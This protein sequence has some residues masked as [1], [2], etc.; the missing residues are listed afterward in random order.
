VQH[1]IFLTA[2]LFPPQLTNN[3]YLPNFFLPSV[4][5]FHI[6]LWT[7]P[8]SIGILKTRAPVEMT[9]PFSIFVKMQNFA[10]F[11]NKNVPFLFFGETP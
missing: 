4:S 6:A 9:K 10:K 7:K 3:T 5:F 8:T 2:C 11:R 1:S